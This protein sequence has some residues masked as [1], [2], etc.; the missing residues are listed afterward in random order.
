MDRIFSGRFSEFFAQFPFTVFLN[1]N[2]KT[3][4]QS[5]QSD[6]CDLIMFRGKDRGPKAVWREYNMMLHHQACECYA[7]RIEIA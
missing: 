6:N 7:I 3:Q 1:T 2:E 5:W 4:R